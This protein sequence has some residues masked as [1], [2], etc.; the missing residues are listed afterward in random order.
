[1]GNSNGTPENS[2][3]ELTLMF[4]SEVYEKTEILLEKVRTGTAKFIEWMNM[5]PVNYKDFM[6]YFHS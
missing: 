5:N 4:P 2:A 6:S 1:M 3:P